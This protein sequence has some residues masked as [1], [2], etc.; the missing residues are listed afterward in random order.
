M[1]IRKS[2]PI[3]VALLLVWD[4]TALA[5]SRGQD[6]PT[7]DPRRGEAAEAEDV[8]PV[9]PVRS[10]IPSGLDRPVNPDTYIVGPSDEFILYIKA[11]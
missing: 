8:I 6:D 3:F 2:I 1:P 11:S 9:V 10:L 5:Q 7:S 4:T